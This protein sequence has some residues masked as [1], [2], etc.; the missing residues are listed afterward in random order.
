MI[1]IEAAADEI[2]ISVDAYRRL[3]SLFLETMQKDT[4]RLREALETE[5]REEILSRAHHIKGA[6]A[7]LEFTVLSVKAEE[8]QHAAHGEEMKQLRA[9]A[10]G[11]F[12]EYNIIKA[13]FEET[14]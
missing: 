3:C 14:I 5:Q 1:D 10:D 8:M 6:A 12:E 4:A 2:G 11:L 7:N 9:M 13:A